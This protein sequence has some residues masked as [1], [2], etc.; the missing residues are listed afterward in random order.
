MDRYWK[1]VDGFSLKVL[2]G[3][4]C[5]VVSEEDDRN[6]RAYI[7]LCEDELEMRKNGYISDNTYDLWADGIRCQ[8]EQAMFRDVWE[9]VKEET[10][11]NCTFPYEHL[12]VLLDAKTVRAGDPLKMVHWRRWVRGLAG[13]RWVRP[14]TETI[15]SAGSKPSLESAGQS[16]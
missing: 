9:E 3:S 2:R 14:S 10:R 12:S 8:F 1:I 16:R 11:K 4:A 7:L 6:I 13:L 5:D 15:S